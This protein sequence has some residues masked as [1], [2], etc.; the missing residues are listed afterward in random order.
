MTTTEL[1]NND[2]MYAAMP[3][4]Q[5]KVQRREQFFD[6]GLTVF[7][8]GYVRS[9]VPA[10]CAQAKLSSRQ[11]YDLF[12][13]RERL[14]LDLLKRVDDQVH[15]A[16]ASVDTTVGDP[17]EAMIGAY[18]EALTVDRRKARLMLV[19]CVT[20]TVMVE[21]E[22]LARRT[23]WVELFH[24]AAAR[25][26]PKL[27]VMALLGAVDAVALARATADPQPSVSEALSAVSGLLQSASVEQ[28]SAA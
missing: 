20:S 28:G 16:V 22:R 23:R 19:S 5:R 26:I 25:S 13:G 14:M 27:H 24:V 4:W 17:L 11:F 7:A 10:I 18:V 12:S 1:V 6:A 2:R 15:A 9:S 3:I 21:T 8:E